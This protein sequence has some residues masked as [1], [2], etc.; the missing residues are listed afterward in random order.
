[1]KYFLLTLLLCLSTLKASAI[2]P[3]VAYWS[4]VMDY[5][6]S[7]GSV[8]VQHSGGGGYTINAS[9]VYATGQ[10]S[11]VANDD[12]FL[13]PTSCAGQNWGWTW[14]GTC[15]S[16]GGIDWQTPVLNSVSAVNWAHLNVHAFCNCPTGSSSFSLVLVKA[17]YCQAGGGGQ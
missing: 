10:Y 8:V 1:M 15:N 11:L 9:N 5:F 7:G 16:K 2:G 4:P 3:C 14:F 6:T 12:V 13:F 17:S